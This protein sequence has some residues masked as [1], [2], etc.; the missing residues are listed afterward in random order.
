MTTVFISGSR[1]IPFLP[2]SSKT[3]IERI[4]ESGFDIVLGDS[5]R[6]VDAA[7]AKFLGSVGY[8]HVAI[9]TIHDAPRIHNLAPDWDVRKIE[10]SMDPKLDGNGRTK[11]ARELETCKD[12]AM[13][14]AADYGLVIWKSVSKSRF[15]KD[16][17]SKGS[18]RNMCQLLQGGRPIV[19]FASTTGSPDDF[20]RHDLKTLK[21]L[22]SLVDREHPAVRKAYDEIA[23]KRLLGAERNPSL[24]D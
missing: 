13:G 21:D 17:V 6:G 5:E 11:N 4:I 10:P 8:P 9:Y 23:K 14:S 20:E 1:E 2:E 7:V 15:G 16:A 24:F 19:L 18:L 22:E 3:A 12:E